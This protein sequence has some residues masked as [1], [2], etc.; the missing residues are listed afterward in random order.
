M[1]TNHR[2]H[3]WHRTTPLRGVVNIRTR[4]EQF[5]KP[6]QSASAMTANHGAHHEFAE[7]TR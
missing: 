1:H 6:H 7:A 4:A 5:F 2:R 3:R